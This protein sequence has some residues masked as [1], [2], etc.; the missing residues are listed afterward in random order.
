[1]V[2][3]SEKEDCLPLGLGYLGIQTQKH[4][5]QT[6]DCQQGVAGERS[7]GNLGLADIVK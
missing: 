6:C 1:M 2:L 4:G 3:E 7:T 5:E